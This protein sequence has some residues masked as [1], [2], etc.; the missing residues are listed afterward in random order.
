MD[1]EILDPLR[2]YKIFEE[3]LRNNATEYVNALVKETGVD[4]NAN[5]ASVEEY[6]DA[7]A[8]ADAAIKRANKSKTKRIVAIIFMIIGFLFDIYGALYFLE[9]V[10]IE[11]SL[12][13]VIPLMV[14]GLILAISMIVLICVKLNKEIRE[15]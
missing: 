5:A 14:V 9:L 3:N 7:S 1:F 6:I 8:S 12:F 13:V 2:E 4:E 15:R 10:S 11:P